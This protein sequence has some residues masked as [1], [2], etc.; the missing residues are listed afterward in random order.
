MLRTWIAS[1]GLL[2]LLVLVPALQSQETTAKTAPARLVVRVP[3]GA[4]LT[5]GDTPT[6]ATGAVRKFDSP[7]L[8][9][10]KT[11]RYSLKAT[12][13]EH[14]EKVVR[15]ESA[16]VQAGKVTEVNLLQA[17]HEEK[18][19]AVKAVGKSEPKAPEPKV[20]AQEE[21]AP[22]KAPAKEDQIPEP[23][24]VSKQAEKKQD[25]KE[26]KDR[27]PDVIFV[28]TP[29][30]VVEKMLELA[31]VKKEDV[32][33]DLGCGDGRIVVTAAKKYGCKG[34]GYDIDPQRVKESLENVE[35]NKVKELVTIKKA[36]IF[37]QD[38]TPANVVTLYLLPSLNVKLM[39]QLA[40]LKPGSRIVSHDFDM[41]GAKPKKVVK[42]MAKD[43]DGN[44]REHTIYYWEVP[45]EKEDKQEND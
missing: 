10:G 3:A 22:A 34:V 42:I 19:T 26:E 31:Q 40:K 14:G 25:K 33:Y 37:T 38:L 24:Q 11:Y 4:K 12:W 5:I 7:A 18:E 36:D 44:E 30:A 9:L 32:V 15:E 45:W 29:N 21:K 17:Q 20:A 43:D 39:P 41:R 35:K 13:M 8:E 16:V 27:E 23:K 1:L 2:S 28:P 6:K